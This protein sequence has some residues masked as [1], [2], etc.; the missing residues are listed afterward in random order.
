MLN[1]NLNEILSNDQT[2]STKV[3]NHPN[4]I[5]NRIIKVENEILQIEFKDEYL[6]LLL[7]VGDTI[8]IKFEHNKVE[9]IIS[10]FVENVIFSNLPTVIVRV[11]NIITHHNVRN[12]IRWN[13]NL[14]CKIVPTTEEFKIQG[15]T[16]DISEGGISMVSYADFNVKDMVNVEI[17]TSQND[18]LKFKG[19]IKR[20]E[21][22]TTSHVQYGIEIVE[23]DNENKTILNKILANAETNI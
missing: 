3:L 5:N 21:A 15:I 9:F 16:T 1:I 14:L 19:N 2:I 11:E 6:K 10:G 22:R 8:N 20:L 23:I 13:I 12:F 4:W 7:T 17:I 18:V